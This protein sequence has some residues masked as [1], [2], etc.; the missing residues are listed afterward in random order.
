MYHLLKI[1][2][3]PAPLLMLGV[4]EKKVILQNEDC[5]ERG[6][7]QTHLLSAPED[8]CSSTSAQV[9]LHS[10]VPGSSPRHWLSWTGAQLGSSAG[11]NDNGDMVC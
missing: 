7:V 8:G 5:K 2:D 10:G 6:G 3:F 11:D 9:F 1:T 4:G